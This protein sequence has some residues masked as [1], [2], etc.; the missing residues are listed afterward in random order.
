MPTRTPARKG[1]TELD[2]RRAVT[3]AFVDLVNQVPDAPEGDITDLLGPILA[4][5]SWEDLQ[6][7]DG[8]PS[9]KMLAQTHSKVRVDMIAKKVSEKDS[10]TGYY[11]LCDG[12]NL[13]TG[14]A[15]RF[16]AGGGQ[17]VAVLSRLYVLGALPAYVEFTPVSTTS[18]NDAIN[19]V[20]LGRDPSIVIDG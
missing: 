16:T 10:L 5:A 12:V 2:R 4:A 1:S 3:E 17:A 18:G 11:L 9:S 20:V 6:R 8:L 7:Q 14:E 19:A 15:F 13:A